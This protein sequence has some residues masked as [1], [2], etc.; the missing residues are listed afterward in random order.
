[1]PGAPPA[2]AVS[3]RARSPVSGSSTSTRPS[4]G[5]ASSIGSRS[6][7]GTTSCFIRAVRSGASYAS[8]R[9]S[10]TT[11]TTVRRFV[12][13]DS[14]ARASERSVPFP[15]GWK[16]R[17]SLTSRSTCLLPFRGGI[18]F[19]TRSLNSKRPTRSL[20]AMAEKAICAATSAAISDLRRAA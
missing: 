7:T 16:E 10:E 3:T 13:R 19:S 1:M 14:Q 5:K 15:C 11:K 6:T 2:S 9:K 18:T 4:A 17:M 20:L 8:S 12:T